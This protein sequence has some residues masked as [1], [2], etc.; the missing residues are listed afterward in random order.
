LLSVNPTFFDNALIL[1]GDWCS[2]VTL[3]LYR[4]NNGCIKREKNKHKQKEAN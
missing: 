3:T 4:R 2:E 1:M